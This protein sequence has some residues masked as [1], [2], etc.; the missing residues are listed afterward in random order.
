MAHTSLVSNIVENDLSTALPPEQQKHP[1]NANRPKKTTRDSKAE[2]GM[3]S[4]VRKLLQ[5]RGILEK[6]ASVIFNCW[7]KSSQRQYWTYLKRWLQFCD[8]RKI[9]PFNPTVNNFLCFLQILF[10]QSL[11]YSAINT[12]K[13]A[14]SSLLSL[15][16][17]ENFGFHVLI[18]RYLKG[19]FVSR[20]MMPKYCC[21]WDVSI[22]IEYLKT[23]FPLSDLSLKS[24][25]CKSIMLLALLTSQ[26]SHTLHLLTVDDVVV[27][28]D[29]VKIR[30]SSLL[31]TS[32]PGK[33]VN[34]VKFPMYVE[35][36]LCIV[37]TIGEYLDRTKPLRKDK[38]LFISTM[39]PHK[40]VSRDTI[41]RWIRDTMKLAG[42]DV[43]KFSPHSTR[44]A[45]TSAAQIAGL[46]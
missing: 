41:S 9:D 5:D 8:S 30:Y 25:S 13:S 39:K 35:Q 27:E 1:D 11:S 10:H 46:C 34:S 43:S 38:K 32:K 24:L 44:A 33:H 28:K 37:K 22:V 2:D 26:R 16:R 40:G 7:R 29:Y 36:E 14:V 42:I 12:A 18:K 4:I 31:K 3:F 17:K 15:C 19:V 20:P 21:T 6:L 23:L 45:A